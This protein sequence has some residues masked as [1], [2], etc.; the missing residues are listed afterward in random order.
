MS[1][2]VFMVIF[3]FGVKLMCVLMFFKIVVM[4]LVENKFGVLFLMKMVLICLLL[5][6]LVFIVKLLRR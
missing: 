3:V 1:G 5:I 4:V 6:C 2:L